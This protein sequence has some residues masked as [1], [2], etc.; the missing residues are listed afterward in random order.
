MVILEENESEYQG[1]PTATSGCWLHQV[2]MQKWQPK[3]CA[4]KNFE[5]AE[6]FRL[7]FM[8]QTNWSFWRKKSFNF[9]K[10]F[11]SVD[12]LV[13]L[14]KQVLYVKTEA[15]EK[16]IQKPFARSRLS[17]KTMMEDIQ[18]AILETKDFEY[19]DQWTIYHFLAFSAAQV[20]H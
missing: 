8:E 17:I 19:R 15:E 11:Y 4:M 2:P 5:Q 1:I 20:F 3:T 6:R 9:E 7:S 12:F 18:P 13:F 10:V 16:T 14:T